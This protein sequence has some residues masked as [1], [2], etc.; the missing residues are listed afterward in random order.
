MAFLTLVRVKSSLS[1]RVSSRLLIALR[2]LLRILIAALVPLVFVFPLIL[3][4]L[5]LL[6]FAPLA[7]LT[8]VI[9]GYWHFSPFSGWFS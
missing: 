8:F 9:I 6:T 4:L 5:T 2:A 7:T 1:G 3:T